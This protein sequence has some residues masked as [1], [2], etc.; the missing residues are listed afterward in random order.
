MKRQHLSMIAALPAA[1]AFACAAGAQQTP[2]QPPPPQMQPAPT[3]T[4]DHDM[5][6]NGMHNGMHDHMR[7]ESFSSLAGRKGY[8]SQS[9]AASHQWLASHFSQC[10]TNRNAE[11]SRSEY[12]KCRREYSSGRQH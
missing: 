11:L 12:N 4:T 7:S 10:D 1:L 2:P 3:T 6:R 8:V 9:D 5:D